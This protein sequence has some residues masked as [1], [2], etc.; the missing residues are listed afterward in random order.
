VIPV[1]PEHCPNVNAEAAQAFA[2]WLLSGAGQQA[3]A[4]YQVSGQQLFFPNAPES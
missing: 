4:E 1:S 3:I 2:D